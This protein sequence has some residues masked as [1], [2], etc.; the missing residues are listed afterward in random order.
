MFQVA[1]LIFLTTRIARDHP[2]DR[3]LLSD[4]KA[5]YK[6]LNE[7]HEEARIHLLTAE[8][9]KI[10]LNVTDPEQQNWE[11]QWVAAKEL[12]INLPYDTRLIKSVR[13]FLQSYENLLLAAGCGRLNISKQ[14]QAPL[15]AGSE[16][17]TLRKMK[18]QFNQMRIKNELTDVVLVPK[19]ARE[20]AVEE[21]EVDAIQKRDGEQPLVGNAV[22]NADDGDALEIEDENINKSQLRAHGVVLAAAI[23]HLQ[24]TLHWPRVVETGEIEFV[25][26]T[27]FGAKCVLGK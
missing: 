11:G 5:T 20:L 14:A 7:H 10:F 4:I 25:G 2:R 13:D 22:E 26:G 24:S 27:P 3:V 16:N 12:V 8:N 15:A 21:L 1:H 9:E 23:P 18:E 6:W 19:K 17:A